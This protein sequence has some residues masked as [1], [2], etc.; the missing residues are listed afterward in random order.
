M[1]LGRALLLSVAAAEVT[2]VDA[3]YSGRSFSVASEDNTVIGLAFNGDG[4]KMYI[5]GYQN[6][7]VY[8]YELSTGFK[9]DTASYSTRSFS[10]AS[11]AASASKIAFS[12]DGTK[13]FT[14]DDTTNTVHSYTLGTGFDV[15]TASYDSVS[16]SVGTEEGNPIGLAFSPDGTR[17]YISGPANDTV[18]EYELSTP[19][20]LSTASYSTRSFSVASQTTAPHGLAFSASGKKMFVLGNDN[21]TV[22]QYSLSTGFKVDTASYDSVSFSV[23]SQEGTPQAVAFNGAGSR[24]F[25]AGSTANTV[26]EYEL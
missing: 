23:T 3:A 6:D 14:S 11:Q 2:L 17:M 15:S 18:F 10:L 5:V 16:V 8:E 4:S 13:M 25:V 21:D 19:F 9:V 24:M 12:P 7:T 22:F 1:L 20:D 26:F